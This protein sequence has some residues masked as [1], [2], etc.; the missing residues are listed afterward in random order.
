MQSFGS[1]VRTYCL[2]VLCFILC[3]D[4]DIIQRLIFCYHLM[5]TQNH[6]DKKNLFIT[7]TTDTDLSPTKENKELTQSI[8]N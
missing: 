8:K 5:L 4:K 1:Y 7:E 3:K 2:L 6:G